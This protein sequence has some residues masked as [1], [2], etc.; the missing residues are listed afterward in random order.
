M[1]IVTPEPIALDDDARLQRAL[2][3]APKRRVLPTG[4]IRVNLI[5]EVFSFAIGNAPRELFPEPDR[6]ADGLS[7]SLG[8]FLNPLEG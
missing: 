7:Q 3:D 6:L 1:V 8:R 4:L 2:A 5:Q